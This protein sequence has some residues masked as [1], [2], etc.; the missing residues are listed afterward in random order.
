MVLNGLPVLATSRIW[1]L[2]QYCPT[3]KGGVIRSAL[4]VIR[5]LGKGFYSVGC[6]H[7]AVECLVSQVGKLLMHYGCESSN[8]AKLH[9][10]L[11]QLII[12]LG[13]SPQPF[14]HDFEK[15]KTHVAWCW[16]VSLWEKCSVYGVKI[17]FNDTPLELPRERDKWLMN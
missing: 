13:L 5:Q 10:S 15:Y 2:L 11:R 4:A 3:R 12:E 8:G 1:S 16:L 9:V 14:Q 17:V 6:P 7:P